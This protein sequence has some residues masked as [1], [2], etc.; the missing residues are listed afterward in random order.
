MEDHRNIRQQRED[1]ASTPDIFVCNFNS[2]ERTA[3]VKASK[4]D[5]QANNGISSTRSQMQKAVDVYLQVRVNVPSWCDRIL[6]KSYPET[7]V[8][9]TAYGKSCMKI[10]T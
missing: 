5:L 6:W 10:F 3:A 7:H 8:A 4:V 1:P 2:F 9:C